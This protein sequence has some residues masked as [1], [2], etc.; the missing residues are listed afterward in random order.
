MNNGNQT[1]AV[2]QMGP[3]PS[4]QQLIE[5]NADLN[6]LLSNNPLLSETV[7]RTERTSGTEFAKSASSRTSGLFDS[8]DY[9]GPSN[10]KSG[11][12]GIARQRCGRC[13]R[14]RLGGA[15]GLWKVSWAQNDPPQQGTCSPQ[16][17]PPTPHCDGS[18]CVAY[19]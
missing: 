13:S 5:D 15:A 12:A 7:F 2:P 10:D 6:E 3:P 18:R 14:G 17:E 4:Y 8:D 9:L 16:C 19:E 11:P 1:A